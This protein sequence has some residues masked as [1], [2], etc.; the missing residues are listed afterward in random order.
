M[1]TVGPVSCIFSVTWLAGDIK[2]PTHLSKRVRVPSVVVWPGLTRNTASHDNHGK[3][4][5]L[6]SFTFLS[7]YG[8][9]L[10]GPLGLIY[11]LIIRY[12]IAY[13][14]DGSYRV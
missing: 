6:V 3:I 7:R 10:P 8:A 4:N 12:G 9:P 2:K 11:Y 5:S 13:F 14:I 1:Y